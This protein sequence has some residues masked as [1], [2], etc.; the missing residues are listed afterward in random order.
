M[1]SKNLER[2]KKIDQIFASQADAIDRLSEGFHYILGQHM[3]E[4]GR[5]I[6]LLKA[7]G[8]REQVVKEQI[9]HSLL[10]HVLSVFDDCYFRATGE[11]WKPQ[12]DNGLEDGDE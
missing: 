5:E 9:K 1:M 12:P 11:L 7:L 6:E 10:Q 2:Q 3:E 4:S 8:G